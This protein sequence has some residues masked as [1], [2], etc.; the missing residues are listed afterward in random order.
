MS[1]SQFLAALSP[2]VE[3]RQVIESIAKTV[4]SIN[5][6]TLPALKAAYELWQG[7]KFKSRINRDFE[8]QVQAVLERKPIFAQLV[9]LTENTLLVLNT[10]DKEVD[11]IFSSHEA[12][13]ALTYAKATTLRVIQA[14]ELVSLYNR[15]ILN[16]AYWLESE[17]LGGEDIAGP[18]PNEQEWLRD[19]M[20]A[21]L[22]ALVAL[23]KKPDEYGPMLRQLPDVPVSDENEGDLRATLGSGNVDPLGVSNLSV[24][25]NP[26]Y[27]I[28]M[29]QADIQA[30]SYKSA[31]QEAQLLEYRLL[32]L[33]QLRDSTQD[34]KL[35]KEIDYTQQRVTSAHAE[36]ARKEKNYHV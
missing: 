32:Q 27:L 20:A 15:R 25:W 1:F 11:K 5:L 35:D 18:T 4:S 2:T 26:F 10:L 9:A 34:A 22:T 14:A 36:L 16:Y 21:Y 24:R 8:A 17:E 3:K 6:Y 23:D 30:S 19:N 13:R 33:Q 12:T 28:G 29:L 7:Q 31:E